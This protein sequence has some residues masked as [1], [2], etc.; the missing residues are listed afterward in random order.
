MKTIKE[1]DREIAEKVM[2][3]IPP[4]PLPKGRYKTVY[5][6]EELD[7]GFV[8]GYRH[9]NTGTFYTLKEWDKY[10]YWTTKDGKITKAPWG[11]LVH[12]SNFYKWTPST[13]ISQAMFLVKKLLLDGAEI[14]IR[15]HIK[16]TFVEIFY[17]DRWYEDYADTTEMAI[18]KA[19]LKAV[20]SQ[21]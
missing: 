7:Y 6:N 8:K 1:I 10:E 19:V 16:S 21:K 18:C 5:E 11:G 2:G 15:P 20:G 9:N 14:I 17:N 3:W 12:R 13:N 4:L